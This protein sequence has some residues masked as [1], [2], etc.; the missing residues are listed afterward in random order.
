MTFNPAVEFIIGFLP[1]RDRENPIRR[2]KQRAHWTVCLFV[3]P[4]EVDDVFGCLIKSS[5]LWCVAKMMMEDDATMHRQHPVL[6]PKN[7]PSRWCSS[8]SGIRLESR[9]CRGGGGG[10]GGSIRSIRSSTRSKEEE[11]AAR[12]WISECGG[13]V[14][15]FRPPPHND[16]QSSQLLPSA[17]PF[18]DDECIYNTRVANYLESNIVSVLVE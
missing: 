3:Q 17:I 8:L 18:R 11:E 10:G 6:M 5:R 16:S 12:K 4:I 13:S 9:D 15:F 14:F 7:R 1:S 2:M